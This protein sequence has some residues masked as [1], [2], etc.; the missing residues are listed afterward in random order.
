MAR[1]LIK[2][3]TKEAERLGQ[4]ID[5]DW[6]Y[7]HE[8]E[9]VAFMAKMDKLYDEGKIIGREYNRIAF[10]AFYDFEPKKNKRR[11]VKA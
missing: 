11:P 7:E 8:D 6:A 10:V 5:T 2:E 9:Y 1:P 4:H 3:L